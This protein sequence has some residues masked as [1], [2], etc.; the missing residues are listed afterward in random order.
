MVT[1]YRVS[2]RTGKDQ[3]VRDR[4]LSLLGHYR[5]S[6]LHPV[7]KP[8]SYKGQANI[9]GLFWMSRLNRLVWYESRLEM[10]ALLPLVEN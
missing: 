4:E 3:W 7:R 9:P 2:I 1:D 8:L 5:P 6:D 10:V